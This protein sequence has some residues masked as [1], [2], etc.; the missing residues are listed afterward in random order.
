[1][2]STT[3]HLL[4]H[5][6]VH[7]P[8]GVLYGR[9]DG[10]H[11]SE[12][13]VA[14][15][16]RIAAHLAGAGPDGAPRRDV[17]HVVASPLHR[18]QETAAPI[19]AAFGLEVVVDPRL[20]EAANHFEGLE[21]GVG[22]GSL[23]RPAHWRF[24]WNPFRPSWGEAYREQVARMLAAITA[25]RDAALGHE[26]VVVSHQLPIWVARQ[27][28]EG[29]RLWHDPRRRQ[30]SLASLTSVTWA[31]DRVRIAYTEPALDLLSDA[32]SVPGA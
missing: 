32:R 4:R 11:L 5:G 21:F 27:A 22:D 8:T 16:E 2:V 7:N 9:L 13:G 20:I 19:A 1:M 25:A 6:E 26:A 12:R 30:C 31:D 15:A 3:V 17:V 10:Y 24:L 23:R 18:A 29:N 28:L 14:M